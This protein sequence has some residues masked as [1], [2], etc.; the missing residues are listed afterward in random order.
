[1][2]SL[3]FLPLV[4]LLV[5]ASPSYAAEEKPITPSSIRG[6]NPALYDRYEPTPG[7][8]FRCLD[9]S[10]AIHYSAIN[11]DYCDCPDGSDEPGT[12]ACSNTSFWCENKGHVPGQV[13]SN[14]VNDGICDPE[15]CD[16]SDEWA[17]G[18]CKN[19][20]EEIGKKHREEEEAIRKTRKTGAKIRGTYIKWAQG[21]KTRLEAELGQ[22]KGQVEEKEKE[23]EKAKVALEKTE[24][25]SKEDLEKKKK[26]PLYQSLLTHRTTLTR[27]QN[28][29][30]RL[31]SELDSLH[32][33]LD[34]L[35]KGYNPNYQDMAVKAAVVGYEE[36]T[37]KAVPKEGDSPE[38]KP[39]VENIKTEQG[40][41]E[42]KENEEEI[43]DWEL[44]ELQR[45]DLDSL[46]WESGDDND[47]NEDDDDEEENGLLWKID[48]YIPD[49]LYD[50]WESVR[51]LAIEWMIRL[52]LIGKK[53]ASKT[54]STE[55]PHVAA[56]REKHRNL[57]NELNKLHNALFNTEETLEKMDKEY[58]PQAE[59]KKLDGV[60]VDKVAGDYT[61]ELCFFGKA[62]Q[63]SNKDSSS[64]HMGTFFEWNSAADQG[65]LPYYSKQL[66]KNGAK[67]WNGPNRSVLVDL[68]CGTQNV[69]LS[70]SEP[71]KCEYRF[72]VTSPALCWPD[73]MGSGA[74]TTK[75]GD[76]P[77]QGQDVKEEL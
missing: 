62:T 31:Q 25:R 3:A 60:C 17:T 68:S 71:E 12:S 46:L 19:T 42:V 49:S 10:K 13:L 24:A 9:G 38:V 69:L 51:D 67:C 1:M 70:I 64:N 56:A 14:R 8:I 77:V 36:L 44:D 40:Q 2:P 75:G 33:I 39:D 16:G 28:K 76:I 57:S 6:L 23:V 61:Y 58:G 63:R 15:C 7:G 48:E 21:E 18:A 37:G 5:F 30:K 4:S 41:G 66:Y 53:K 27:L 73:P 52:G 72:K 20:C 50:S 34:E 11:D 59:W 43:K 26:S 74:E 55:R 29:S 45:K 47:N 65:S 22:K 54:T 32:S 35:S